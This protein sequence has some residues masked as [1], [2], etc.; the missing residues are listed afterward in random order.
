MQVWKWFPVRLLNTA[1]PDGQNNWDRRQNAAQRHQR[2]I[3]NATLP[4]TRHAA[5]FSSPPRVT[6]PFR[7]PA[8]R[9]GDKTGWFPGSRL[10]RPSPPSQSAAHALHLSG[11]DG[12]S[13]PPTVAG[14]ASVS[15]PQR[16]PYRVPCPNACAPERRSATSTSHRQT[17]VNGAHPPDPALPQT[18]L[19]LAPST[20]ARGAPTN[21]LTCCVGKVRK[22]PRHR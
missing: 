11:Y 22:P 5:N 1:L 16:G 3:E 12:R 14:S 7:F 17:L 10:E 20:V 9:V 8:E 15:A 4:G 6:A 13:L 18:G 19:P 2:T 21:P